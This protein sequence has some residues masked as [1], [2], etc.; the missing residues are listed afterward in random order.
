[1]MEIDTPECIALFTDFGEQGPYLG[2]VEM[3]LY[4]A[5]TRQPLIRLFNDAPAF[6]PRASAYL[7]AALVGYAPLPTL[8]LGVVDP[9]VG[10]D[11]L[12]LIL[13]VDGHWLVGPDNGLF[14]Q[15]VKQGETA[16]LRAV[17]WLPERLSASFHGRDLFAPVAACLATGRSVDSHPVDSIV[18]LGWPEQLAEVIYIDP[19]GNACTGLRGDGL[20]LGL[21]VSVDGR[22]IH[23]AHTF[24]EAPVGAPFW[25]VNSLGLL[26]FAVNQGHAAAELGLSIGSS[27]ALRR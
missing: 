16:V 24:G 19:Y 21:A 5:G 14:S 9:G 13:R 6:D 20:D 10:G 22:S 15:V 3:A 17:D 4:Q 26:E 27:I 12:P 18:G 11:R 23:H 7:L 8:F 2:Q 25:Y 1:M